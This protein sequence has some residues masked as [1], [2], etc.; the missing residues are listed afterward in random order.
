VGRRIRSCTARIAASHGRPGS[1]RR[2]GIEPASLP[3]KGK[4]LPLSYRR[5]CEPPSVCGSWT[6]TVCTND[7]A[8]RNLVALTAVDARMRPEVLDEIFGALERK[9]SLAGLGLGHVARAVGS[10][11]LSFVIRTA[12][13]AVVVSLPSRLPAPRELLDRLELLAAAAAPQPLVLVVGRHTEHMF[14]I[15]GDTSLAAC[16]VVQRRSR[17]IDRR[18]RGVAQSGS[19]PG[20]GPGGRR[21]KSCLPDSQKPCKTSPCRMSRIPSGLLMFY[22][23]SI[24]W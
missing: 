16:L 23:C 11:V 7:V 13:D 3:W 12:Q 15:A 14:A 6:M 20:W 5:T 10:V 17:R 22:S 4:A 19:A 1:K 9:G 2:T 24:R 8:L 18:P 21:F